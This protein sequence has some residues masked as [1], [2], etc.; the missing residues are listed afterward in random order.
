[1]PT[2]SSISNSKILSQSSH[3]DTAAMGAVIRQLIIDHNKRRQTL[4]A[5]LKRIHSLNNFKL[6]EILFAITF[7]LEPFNLELVCT[8]NEPL[9][10]TKKVFLRKMQNT[11]D[12]NKEINKEDKRK[13]ILFSILEVEND[14]FTQIDALKDCKYFQGNFNIEDWLKS[15][16]MDGYITSKNDEGIT[17]WSRN[18]RYYVEYEDF[19]NAKDYFKIYFSKN[20]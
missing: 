9:E 10:K 15:L 14:E 7:Y 8:D 12:G 4:T 1:M 16:K 19:F 5:D 2:Q 17:Y 13:Y 3:V 6:N 11:N 18:W 20:N